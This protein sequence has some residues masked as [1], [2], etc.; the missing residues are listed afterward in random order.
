VRWGLTATVDAPYAI[1]MLGR[2]VLSSI[3]LR[4]SGGLRQP[5]RSDRGIPNRGIG[6]LHVGGWF[7]I[8]IAMR[9]MAARRIEF[10]TGGQMRIS[11]P[12]AASTVSALMKAL[13]KGKRSR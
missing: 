9:G 12:V 3:E 8:L 11:G 7:S 10:T 4:I 6:E 1:A 5:R 13:A 2:S